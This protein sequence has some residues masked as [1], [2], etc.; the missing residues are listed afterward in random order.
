MFDNACVK[1]CMCDAFVFLT[2]KEFSYVFLCVKI[3]SIVC[4]STK[5]IFC[6]ETKSIFKLCINPNQDIFVNSG[7][8]QF[9][10]VIL[11]ILCYHTIQK[12]INSFNTHKS[13]CF[14]IACIRKMHNKR[15]ENHNLTWLAQRMRLSK[16]GL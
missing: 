11:A 13:F 16:K 6:N 4:F 15:V 12:F 5:N 2:F 14:V 8:L 9:I 1:E 7:S 10:Y 3:V